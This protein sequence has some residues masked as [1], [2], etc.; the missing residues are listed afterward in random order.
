VFPGWHRSL[1]QDPALLRRLHLLGRLP[2][3]LLLSFDADAVYGAFDYVLACA[4]K[5][6]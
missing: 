4:R 2:Y 5:P 1:A 6:R 3:R